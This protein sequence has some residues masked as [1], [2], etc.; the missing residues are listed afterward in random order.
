MDVL[1]ILSQMQNHFMA[2]LQDLEIPESAAKN[3]NRTDNFSF[4]CIH[5]KKKTTCPCQPLDNKPFDSAPIISP[6]T[7]NA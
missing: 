6:K 1:W 5:N 3:S 4:V 7:Q 2:Q